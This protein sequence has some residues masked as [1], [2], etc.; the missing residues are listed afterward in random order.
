MRLRAVIAVVVAAVLLGGCSDEPKKAA[1][2][3]IPTADTAHNDTD[4][5]F[6][7]MMVGHH[8]QGLQLTTL[9]A[10]R[11]VRPEVKELAAAI[12]VTES[13]EV[14]MMTAWLAAWSRPD[15]PPDTHDGHV[16]HGGQPAVGPE[17]VAGLAG[18]SGTAFDT[19]FLALMA[20]HQGAAVEM[21]GLVTSG[22]QN[23][24]TRELAERI[25][26][27]RQGQVAMMIRLMNA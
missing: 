16:N 13:E 2:N 15:V 22:G 25:G 6:L 1:P 4:V 18:M 11:A 8:R 20:G 19:E 27:A 12:R 7:Q 14:R 10:Q 5:M 17:Q 21:V 9:A 23:P 24:Q 3:P 26:K